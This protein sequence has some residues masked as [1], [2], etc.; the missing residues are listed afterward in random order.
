MKAAGASSDQ[1]SPDQGRAPWLVLAV[2]M[3]GACMTVLDVVIVN[4]AIPSVRAEMHASFGDAEM[5]ISAYT[6]TYA[7]LL[8]TGGRLGDLYGRKRLFIIGITGFAIASA[9][10]GAAPSIGLLIAARA[11]QG[12]AG[13]LMYPQVLAVIQVTFSGS[14]RTRALGVFGAVIGLA[15]IGGQIIGGLL[16]AANIFGLTWRPVFLVNVPLGVIA[17]VAAA[18]LLPSDRAHEATRLDLGGVGLVS[19]A[20]L[21]LTVPLL[22]GRD[23]GWPPVMIISLIAAFPAGAL[24]VR[25]ERRLAARGGHPLVRMD[26]FRNRS[27]AGGVPIALLFTFSYAG[28]LLMLTVYLQTGLGFSPL[29]AALTYIPAAAGFFLTSLAAPRLVPVLGRHVLTLGYSVAALGLFG[30]AATAAAAGGHLNG[31]ELAPTLLIAGLGQ[32]LGMSPLVGT[33]ISGVEPAEAGA[34]SGV[35]TTTLQVGNVLGVGLTGLVFFGLVGAGQGDAVYAAAFGRTLPISAVAL[36]IAAVFV[37]RLPITPFEAQNALI[38]RLPGWASGFAYS[39]FLMTG[40][41]IGDAMF[42]SILGRI[43]RERMEHIQEAPLPPGEFLAYH[44]RAAAPD[45]AWVSYLAREGLASGPGPVPHETERQAVIQAQ[46]DEIRRRQQAGL[47]PAELDPALLRLLGFA[48]VNYPRLLPQ[49]TRMTTGL[50]PEDPGFRASWEEF[51]RQ[52]G[53]RLQPAREAVRQD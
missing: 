10:C 15:A 24:F 9:L 11:L 35:V 16:L 44:F 18:T 8:V 48:L 5:A 46:V 28:F 7:C 49:I 50:P 33:I 22:A 45:A 27:F 53:G 2:V 6:L 25:Y 4:V 26:L 17:A 3:A 51:L 41:R 21:L 1:G 23:T 20:L 29:H 13:S 19:V 36:L 12:A 37:Y 30:A 40:G 34:A 32:G 38:D 39:M 14:Q 43:T 42:G 52:I 31:L 47:L